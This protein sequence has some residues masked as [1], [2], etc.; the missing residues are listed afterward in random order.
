MAEW[1]PAELDLLEDALE[2]L[3]QDG[4]IERWLD[5]EPRPDLR[6]RLED[7][8]ILLEASREA[9]PMVDVPEGLLD[10]VI[11]E[12]R[13][14]AA[15]P[16]LTVTSTTSWWTRL[17]RSVLVPA[18][19][20]AG[21]AMLVLWIG[22]PEDQVATVDAPVP[23]ETPSLAEADEAPPAAAAKPDD[24]SAP[25]TATPSA[26]SAAAPPPADGVDADEEVGAVEAKQEPAPE[27]EP[28]LAKDLDDKAAEGSLSTFGE[29][30]TEAQ[31]RAGAGAGGAAPA[32]PASGRWDLISL[33]DRARN[34]GDCIAARDEY[35]LALEDD[36]PRV[37]ARALAGIGLCNAMDGDDPAAEANFERARELD[38]GID[39]FIESQ[40]Q[41][42]AQRKSK[43]RP[44]KKKS[45]SKSNPFQ[46]QQV[47]PFG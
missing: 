18:L 25:A 26:Q 39:G 12:A 36:D 42:G 20:L 33:G 27:P 3:E 44:K 2:D 9:M 43:R 19:A 28:E 10:D 23:A 21:T 6:E 47:D 15:T 30:P 35:S 40:R 34:A 7:Y 16:S 24:A 31:K 29:A 41:R 32:G 46:G 14:A 22:R 4:A 45:S 17:R 1:T 11:E 37:R 38:D 8:R 5:D 13:K